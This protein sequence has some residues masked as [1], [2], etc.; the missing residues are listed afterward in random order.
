MVSCGDLCAVLLI[1]LCFRRFCCCSSQWYHPTATTETTDAPHCVDAAPSP[2]TNDSDDVDADDLTDVADLTDADVY[3]QISNNMI[4]YP[5]QEPSVE[6]PAQPCSNESPVPPPTPPIQR[7]GGDSPPHLELT[8]APFQQGS[9]GAL[10]P[11]APQGSLLYRVTQQVLG[12]SNW[13]PFQSQCDWEFARWAKMC[14]PTSSAVTELLAIPEA[15]VPHSLS[16]VANALWKV[17]DRLGLSYRNANEL[18][19]IIDKELPGRPAFTCWDF[20]IGNETLHFYHRNIIE[21]IRTLYSDPEFARDMVFV[22]ERHYTDCERTCRVYSEMHTGD[23][24][25]A[26]QVRELLYLLI[27]VLMAF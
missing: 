10:V 20:S 23:W 22:P 25:W 9:A 11:D 21:C 12:S 26:V 1:H 4:V 18:N 7:D 8:V 5:E 19:N 27:Q 2:A 6:V 3:E 24:W 17:V 16:N 13:A 14:G 15:C